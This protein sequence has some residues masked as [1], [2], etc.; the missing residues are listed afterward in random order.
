MLILNWAHF[1]DMLLLFGRVYLLLSFLWETP[2]KLSLFLHT[3]LRCPH[4]WTALP[5]FSQDGFLSLLHFVR[6]LWIV[7]TTFYS[8]SFLLSRPVAL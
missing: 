8:H 3:L 2:L 6:I 7:G 5:N 4:P 1:K